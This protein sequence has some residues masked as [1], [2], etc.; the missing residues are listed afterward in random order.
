M[1]KLQHRSWLVSLHFYLKCQLSPP[2][3]HP[4]ICES[5][6]RGPG[7]PVYNTRPP[8]PL[9]SSSQTEQTEVP[10][11][12]GS[13][14]QTS[15]SDSLKRFRELVSVRYM[16]WEAVWKW[17]G[18][19]SQSPLEKRKRGPSAAMERWRGTD[20]RWIFWV[21]VPASP[22]SADDFVV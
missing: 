20:L 11:H 16:N 12:R 10:D 5:G 14:H 17:W 22:C 3:P 1:R 2:H 18:G 13:I 21:P 19:S 15:Q 7:F 9:L 8:Q 4:L 6:F